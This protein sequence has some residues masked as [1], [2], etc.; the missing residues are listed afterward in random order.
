MSGP[1]AVKVVWLD[2]EEEYL[3]QGSHITRFAN[4][5]RAEDLRDFLKEGMEDE[6]QSIN[7]VHFPEG[8]EP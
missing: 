7:V 1:W 4:R 8:D 3:A 2:G 6:V 5:E